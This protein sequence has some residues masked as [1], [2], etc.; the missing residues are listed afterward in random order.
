MAGA[1]AR[2]VV[3][4]YKSIASVDLE[5]GQINVLVGANGAGKSNFL[6]VFDLIGEM[7]NENLRQTVARLGG[8]ERL[9]HFG[10]KKTPRIHTRLE[11]GA[12][13]YEA[14][15]APAQGGTLFFESEQCWGQGM[16]YTKPFVAPLGVGH[17]ESKLPGE[18]RDP[19]H[20]VAQWTLS[21]MESWKRFHFHDTSAAAGIKQ[22]QPIADNRS[23]RRDAANLAPFLFRLRESYPAHYQRITSAIR[24][25]APFFADFV[26]RP[27]A[28]NEHLISLEWKPAEG[29]YFGSPHALSDGTLR[30]MCLATLLLQPEPPS[31]ILIDEPELGLHPFA[32]VALADI[33]RATS[34]NQQLI[35]STQSV[36]LLNQFEVEDVV[37]VDREGGASTFHRLKPPDLEVWLD[38]YAI[39][40]M[41]EKNL[42]GGRPSRV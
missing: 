18:A 12:N 17:S 2:V 14:S 19:Q 22:S 5:L 6:E 41:W 37:V 27:D 28:A 31:L 39:G 20:R 7:I 21:A 30:F 1:L 8:S 13:G 36:T 42:I 40:E 23:L 38:E 32:I 15:L 25:V 24:Q 4:G 29:D 35:L 33:I 34:V 9:L 26:M 11:F 3:D 16:A 10:S